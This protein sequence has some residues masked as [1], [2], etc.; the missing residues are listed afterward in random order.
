MAQQASFRN[1]I[2]FH[3]KPSAF[4]TTNKPETQDPTSGHKGNAGLRPARARKIIPLLRPLDAIEEEA[5]AEEQREAATQ[6]NQ[7]T[8]MGYT[9]NALPQ[10]GSP[11][12]VVSSYC[13]V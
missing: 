11:Q 8:V 10:R 3:S 9:G 13:P 7:A 1:A 2:P 5:T 6:T 4:P 12:E